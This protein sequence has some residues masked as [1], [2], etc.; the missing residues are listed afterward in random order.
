MI[1]MA[2]DHARHIFHEPAMIDEPT[3]LATT[4]PILFFTRWITHFCAPVFLFLSGVSAYISGQKKTKVQLSSFLIKRGVWLL[5][6]ELVIITFG[7]SFN[8]AYNLFFL[9]VI[10]AIGWSMI[11]LGLLVRT[12]WTVIILVGAIIFFV[13]NALD[14]VEI[15]GNGIASVLW[16]VLFTSSGKIYAV[17]EGRSILVLYAILPWTAIM[18]AGFVA[19]RLYRPGYDKNKRKDILLFS[20]MLLLAFY[21]I[22]RMTNGYG[23]PMPWSEQKNAVYTFLSFLNVAKYPV[24]LQYSCMTL[25][26]ALITLALVEKI[27]N[28]LVNAISIFGRVP[29]F[30]Y[31]LHFYVLHVLCVALFFISGYGWDKVIDENSFMFFRPLDFGFGLS[32]VYIIWVAVV[33]ILYWPCKWFSRYKKTHKQWWL[34]YV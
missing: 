29:F 5:V 4:T 17:G 34:S 28:R 12:S 6:V 23:D 10:W 25:G 31:V 13:H 1:I 21:I 33:L 16:N 26:P 15:P 27:K 20:G 3:N 2:L 8:P 18:I 9:Q 22:L 30:Y 32:I 24:S 14:Y 7:L 11:I 19:G